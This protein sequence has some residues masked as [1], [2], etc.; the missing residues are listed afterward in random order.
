MDM[1]KCEVCTEDC[2][3][4]KAKHEAATGRM[5]A[6][7]ELGKCAPYWEALFDEDGKPRINSDRLRELVEADKDGRCVVLPPDDYTW[8]IR[9]DVI[10]DL[11]RVNCRAA[12]K[13]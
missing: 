2:P 11:I 9:G 8:T 10:R 7:H 12:K 4:A 6:M 13:I 5:Y 3:Q 1:T